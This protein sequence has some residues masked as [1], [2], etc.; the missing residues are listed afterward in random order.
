MRAVRNTSDGVRVVDVPEPDREAAGVRV[1]VKAAG[2]CASDLAMIQAGPLPFTLGHEFSGVTEDGRPVAIEPIIPCATCDQCGGGMYHRCRL[3][4]GSN[5]GFALDGGMCES[6]VV[7]E[8]CLVPLPSGLRV[9]DAFLAEPMAVVLHGLHLARIEAGM[10]VAVVGGGPVGLMSVAAVRALG[11]EV[12]LQARHRHQS[13][14][15]ERLGAKGTSGEYDLVIDAATT[16][17]GLVAAAGLA[18]PGAT[19][20]AVAIYFDVM[21][22]PGLT[23]L[24]KELR[25][26][27]P[28]TYGRHSAGRDF[29]HAATLL[30]ANPDIAASLVTHRFPLEDAA[31]A[32]RQAADRKGGTIKVALE[33]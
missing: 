26:V 17:D 19:L 3:G 22:L 11:C 7:P 10:R 5:L 30:A 21:P 25:V 29:D 12:G 16:K 23:S 28:Y 32:F 9:E 15:G 20:L 14:V 4:A 27:L 8:R 33:P 18:A 24:M 31:A 1:R 6:V 2:V 13:E